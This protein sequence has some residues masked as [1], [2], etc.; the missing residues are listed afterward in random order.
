MLNINNLLHIAGSKYS[1]IKKAKGI[2]VLPEIQSEQIKVVLE[3]LV[4]EI[5]RELEAIKCEHERLR[6]KVLDI[7]YS[8]PK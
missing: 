3:V 4:G 5:N 1:L 8:L 7:K 2:D 6:S